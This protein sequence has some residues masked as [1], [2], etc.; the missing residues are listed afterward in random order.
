MENLLRAR[1]WRVKRL[2]FLGK[3]GWGRME[4]PSPS[5]TQSP[6]ERAM[7]QTVRPDAARINRDYYDRF[8]ATEQPYWKYMAAPRARVGRI[9][10]LTR[11]MAPGLICDFGCGNGALLLAVARDF[12]KAR[13]VG[14]DLSP[15]Q[16]ERNR[17]EHPK[18]SWKEADLSA[19]LDDAFFDEAPAL[20]LSSEVIEHLDRPDAYLRNIHRVLAPGG[21]LILSTQSGKIRATE[22]HVGHVRHFSAAEMK[23][24][25][26]R[27][28][29][30]RVRVWNEGFPFHDLSKVLANLDP[31]KS[32]KSFDRDSYGPYQRLVS[33]VLRGLYLFNTKGR[34][35]QL[36]AVAE[37]TAPGQGRE[38]ENPKDSFARF[39]YEWHHYD[40]ILPE[41]ETQFRRWTPFFE[42]SDWKGRTFLDV[43][44]GMGRNSY[45]PMTYGAA[46]GKAVDLDERSLTAARRNL[47]RFPEVAVARE[48]AYQL[49]DRGRFD[50]VFSIG[51]VHHLHDP[52][53]AL[54]SMRDA[55][56]PGGWVCLWL[57][58]F[59]N[60]EWVVRWFDPL[61][62]A[63]FSRLPIG[64]VHALSILPAALLMALVRLRRNPPPYQRFLRTVSFPHLRSIVFD[65]MLPEI[66]HYYKRDEVLRLMESANLTDIEIVW[67]NE[68]SW[69]ARGRT[70]KA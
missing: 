63:L 60:N 13:L 24:A 23:E 17:R 38:S 35:A 70:P 16:L 46:G 20:G 56:R 48:S 1:I 68:L 36:Y 2:L 44:C 28:G 4:K 37:K 58:G 51:V 19:K 25:L 65:Q 45:W 30:S 14:I 64:A 43:G 32:I 7:S 66:A 67:V 52:E 69:A 53:R 59:E 12:P 42:P 5:K 41:Y 10:K 40:E 61:R 39:G 3:G 29:F 62:R 6:Y 27:A 11:D 34:G 9:R 31:E 33:A 47:A 55:A 50:V 22:R 21:R 18:I 8:A 54:A 26:T 49:S 57:Y 15:A